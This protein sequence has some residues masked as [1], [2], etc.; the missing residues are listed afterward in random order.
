MVLTLTSI[1][2]SD[3]ASGTVT[4]VAAV[5]GV[6][7]KYIQETGTSTYIMADGQTE[8]REFVYNYAI[9]SNGHMGNFLG[10]TDTNN[11]ETIVY[12]ANWTITSKTVSASALASLGTALT[13]AEIAALPSAL[14][15]SAGVVASTV[16]QDWGA[17][18]TTYY[19]AVSGSVLGYS[20]ANLYS[21]NYGSGSSTIYRDADRMEIGSSFVN[22]NPDG[23]LMDYGS[24]F[25]IYGDDTAG[26]E[27]SS[28][29]KYK[30][31]IDTS[32]NS[33]GSVHRSEI[34]YFDNDPS[35]ATYHQLLKVV[36][37][38]LMAQQLFTGLIGRLS[39]KPQT[40]QQQVQ[41]QRT[42]QAF[43]LA[44]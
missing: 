14:Q 38:L 31:T 39:V 44:L 29:T 3:D 17:V 40:F 16:T 32:Y 36:Q 41:Q 10:G 35:S 27:F 11:G 4:G 42:Y 5:G 6:N 7:T 9:D 23:T 13:S 22:N 33:D 24:I 28:A 1:T 12:D 2:V 30:K 18:E 21:H 34:L 26:G 15:D 37:R 43:Q 19:G 25:T 20:E 8:T